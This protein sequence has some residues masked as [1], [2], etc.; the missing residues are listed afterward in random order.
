MTKIN[1]FLL[2]V[3][4]ILAYFQYSSCQKQERTESVLQANSG[5]LVK[6]RNKYNQE[7]SKRLA[8]VG[9]V[10][11]LKQEV[12]RKDSL[13]NHL[14]DKITN[15][16]LSFSSLKTKTNSNQTTKTDTV[17]LKDTVVINDVVTVYPEYKSSFES[18]WETYS[19]I[20]TKDSIYHTH[21]IFNFFDIEQRYV[22]QGFLKPRAV[23][24]EIINHNP[25]TITVDAQSFLI[26]PKK[27]NRLL[28]LTGCF[29]AGWVGCAVLNR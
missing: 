1:R 4:I 7:V 3:I 11:E 12:N 27:E 21:E 24:V 19:I 28:W 29:L 22:S 26:K 15:N 2:F 14:L 23:A 25:S 10:K 18:D 20:A 16:T 17:V 9:T 6:T 5:V 13:I 8:L